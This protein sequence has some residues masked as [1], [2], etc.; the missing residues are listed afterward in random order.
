M[1]NAI[2]SP[3]LVCGIALAGVVLGIAIGATGIGGV[4]LVPILTL[5]L[6]IDV[7]RA[8]A[9]TLLSYV[10]SCLVAVVLY[11]RRGSI[12]WR[13]ASLLCLASVPAA[14]LGARAAAHA[15]ATLLEAAIGALLLAGGLYALRTPRIAPAQRIALAPAT[16][17]GLG[18]STGFVSAMT[19]AGG[20]F[21]LLPL[22]LLLDTP[23]L[24]AIGLGQAIAMPI[25]GLASLVNFAA[26]LVDLRLAAGLA[27]ALAAGI[28]IG[29]PIA[30][31]LPQQRLRRLLGLVVALA[32]TAM[33]LRTTARLL[34]VA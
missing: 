34:G 30:H 18:G 5:A 2:M 7:K 27:V 33:L 9:A 15:P 23:V 24:A 19:G 16:L 29:T 32:G 13:E 25:A 8:I 11:A 31:A 14:W 22:L 6:G 17:L 26:G 10:P 1:A 20:A 3:E 21:M 12:P 4:L 28:A